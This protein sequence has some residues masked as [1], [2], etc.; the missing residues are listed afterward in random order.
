M[1][2]TK[3]SRL[4]NS[5]EY[6][7]VMDVLS[8]LEARMERITELN[9]CESIDSATKLSLI[10]QGE[11]ALAEMRWTLHNNVRRLVW[12]LEKL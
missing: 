3:L 2:Q 11:S 9:E 12:L 4:R 1:R 5:E 7:S 6:A 10:S 8:Q